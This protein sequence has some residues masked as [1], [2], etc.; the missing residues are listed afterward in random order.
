MPPP[1]SS[2]SLSRDQ[3]IRTPKREPSPRKHSIFSPSQEVL[4]TIS[5]IPAAASRSTWYWIIGLPPTSSRGLGV[6]SVR[7]RKRSPKPAA[8]IIAFIESV[9]CLSPGPVPGLGLDC[10]QQPI[11]KPLVELGKFRVVLRHLQGVTQDEWQVVEIA[12]LAVPQPQP[13]EDTQHLDMALQPHQ[14]EPGQQLVVVDNL[15][16]ADGRPGAAQEIERARPDLRSRPA[17]IAILE[18]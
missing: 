3:T 5:R 1:V 18:Q 17:N 13:G 16:G 6:V 9:S 10:G 11:A 4:M 15:A 8:R 14:V 2:G 12:G 7:G